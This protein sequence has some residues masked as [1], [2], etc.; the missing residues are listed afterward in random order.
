MPNNKTGLVTGLIEKL[1][2]ENAPSNIASIGRYVLTPDI[3]Y[4]L[5]NQF[6]V[7][8]GEIQLTDSI[9]LQAVN[10]MVE[11]VFLNGQRFDCGSI[12]GYGEAINHMASNHKFD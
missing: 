9:N 10:N 6:V 1:N 12:Q 7:V 8:A 3:F 4:I 5:R 11:T 2:F